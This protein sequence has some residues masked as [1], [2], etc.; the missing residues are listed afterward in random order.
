MEVAVP[1]IALETKTKTKMKNGIDGLTNE[2]IKRLR[3]CTLSVPLIYRP[4]LQIF[5]MIILTIM[6]TL[7]TKVYHNG[8]ERKSF[9]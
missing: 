5:T 4:H 9:D 7:K 3:A 8:N 2:W 6:P 1:Q